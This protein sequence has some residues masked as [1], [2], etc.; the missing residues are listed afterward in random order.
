MGDHRK[1]PPEPG[2]RT[3]GVFLR[4]VRRLGAHTA[5]HQTRSRPDRTTKVGSWRHAK[6]VLLETGVTK[7]AMLSNDVPHQLKTAGLNWPAVSAK[8]TSG[9]MRHR[10]GCD[11][12]L[13]G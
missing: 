2:N 9:V 12:I 7:E 3:R 5:R 13:E 1:N 10:C 4:T 11:F 8:D 6:G